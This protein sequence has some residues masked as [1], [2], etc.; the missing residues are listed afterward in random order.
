MDFLR[1]SFQKVVSF[2]NTPNPST[3]T[4][5]SNS[6]SST[7]PTPV[8]TPR[9]SDEIV[10][11]PEKVP[12]DGSF[13]SV[14]WSFLSSKLGADVLRSGI[15]LPSY[16]Y[17]P[18]SILQRQAEMIEH[19]YVL[20]EAAKC[21]DGVEQLA[22]VCAFAVSGY[23]ST[24]RFKPSFNPLLGETFE[25]VDKRSNTKFFAEQVSHHPPVSA[26]HCE[27]EQWK[28]WQNSSPTTKFLGNSLD[29]NTH[30]N[31]YISFRESKNQFFYTNPSTRVQSVIFGS[32]RIEHYGEL[33]IRNLNGSA[34]ALI[35]FTKSGYFQGTQYQVE[36]FIYDENK[37]K[38]V[39]LSG[40]WDSHLTATW[41][42]NTGNVKAG[43]EKV[44][45]KFD[46]EPV[47]VEAHQFRPFTASLNEF[48]GISQVVL[49]PTD[50]RRR[51]DR[52]FLEIGDMDSASMYKR[53]IEEQQRADKRLRTEKWTPLWFKPSEEDSENSLW[54]YCGNY[55]EQ[56]DEKLALLREGKETEGLLNPPQI[57]GLACDFLSY[58]EKA[59]PVIQQNPLTFTE[60]TNHL[61]HNNSSESEN[62]QPEGPD[63]TPSD[64]FICN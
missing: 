29:L 12:E 64:F 4:N 28:F 23:S 61:N 27:N 6:A 2:T 58:K 49:L 15:S 59:V 26:F 9:N 57:K 10:S 7:N 11:A 25:Y 16:M 35:V 41:L 8:Q 5:P 36:G 39:K 44:L 50:S 32:I 48:D 55:W 63:K 18:L 46:P 1:L 37:N 34:Q 53:M 30:G 19:A 43:T 17:E 52:Y 38:I 22:Y 3:T 14:L 54:I 24:Q 60:E 45:W 56:K 33:N 21:G 47:V 31:S 42:V 40:R 13:G 62:K 20:N 51:L